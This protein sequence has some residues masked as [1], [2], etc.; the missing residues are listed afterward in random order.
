MQ[1]KKSIIFAVLALATLS[2]CKQQYQLTD[3]QRTRVLINNRYD[4]SPDAEAVAFIKP[5]QSKVDS[6]MKPVVGTIDH[7]MAARK[8]ESDLSNLL[9]DI[10][11]W[12]GEAFQEKP[13]FGV[14]NMGG[15]RAAFAKGKVTYG[16]VLNVAPFENHICFLTLTGEKTLQLFREMASVGG[17]GVSHGVKLVITKDGKLI[18][19]TIGGKEIDP[20]KNYRIVTLDYL[21]QGND[22]LE[23]FKSKT[24]VVSP[25][26]KNYST[27]QIIVNYFKSKAAKGE[28]VNAQMEG[29][30]SYEKQI[31]DY[32]GFVG[33]IGFGIWT[34][35]AYYFAYQ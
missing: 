2:S 28:S 13:D 33:R 32:C 29:R 34:K 11:V 18:S 15:I 19:A 5:Y 17:E 16:D 24:N 20:T 31:I 3:V 26:G 8:P 10:L 7:F 4:S 9:A 12:G 27:R 14:Y 23:A 25:Q 35:N 21:A 1:K 22:K 6:M 30:I